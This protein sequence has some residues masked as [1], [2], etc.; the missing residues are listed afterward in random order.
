MGNYSNELFYGKD[1]SECCTNLDI[2]P[3]FPACTTIV[4]VEL[5]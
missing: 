2:T 3:A 4:C 1:G 5:G